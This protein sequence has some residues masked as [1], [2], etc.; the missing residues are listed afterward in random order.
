MRLLASS[1]LVVGLVSATAAPVG[2]RSKPFVVRR[3]VPYGVAGGERLLLDAYLSRPGSARP[4]VIFIHGGGFRSGDKAFVAPGEQP[5][6]SIA[7]AFVGRGFAVFS[8][9][10][11][12]A[13]RFPFPAALEDVL[14]A[15]RWVR[16][17]AGGLGVD[18]HRIALFGA[19][20]GGN[21]AVLAAVGGRGP[22]DRGS[23]VRAGV[24][25]SGPM[26]LTTFYP[27]H[28]F[29]AA[30]LGCVPSACPS[31]YRAASPVGSVDRGDP[32]LLLVTGSAE[33]VPLGQA[34]EMTSRLNA[35]HVPHELIV[36]PGNRHAGEYE[37]QV[38]AATVRFLA[39]S[40]AP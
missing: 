23:R 31:R 26:D 2:A 36:V 21:L 35:E 5:F 1:L 18:P 9:D 3:N 27:G 11:R 34:R 13:P 10:Y 14:R 8:I 7:R 33:I 12:L 39:R 19:S 38:W 15:V 4:A 17:H 30:Y 24:S 32:P 25:W 20:A 16:T 28:R 29:V 22:L 40:L 37:H 6:D